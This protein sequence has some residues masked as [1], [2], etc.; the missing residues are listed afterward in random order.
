LRY[1]V[2]VKE[3][4]DSN[5]ESLMATTAKEN[6]DIVRHYIEDAWNEANLDLIDK[7]VAADAPHHDQTLSERPDGPAGRE[8]SIQVYHTACPDVYISIQ[9]MV[10]EN[11]LVAVRW[12]G[13]GTHEGELVGVEPT[14]TAIEITGMSI[15]R[16]HEGQIAETWEVYD[17]LGMPQQIGALPEQ[18]TG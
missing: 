14:G 12:I 11:D 10:A 3:E 7:P 1:A 18:T 4:M 9:E 8:Q 2:S 6:K 5:E 13:R 17:T 15:N 16:M